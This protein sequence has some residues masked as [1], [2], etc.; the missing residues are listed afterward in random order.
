[1]HYFRLLEMAVATFKRKMVLNVSGHLSYVRD[2][3]L[4]VNVN[5]MRIALFIVS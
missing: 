1:M 5:D 4:T 3:L 2:E